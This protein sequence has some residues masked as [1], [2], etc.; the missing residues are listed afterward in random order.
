MSC[1][2]CCGMAFYS[3]KGSHPWPGC[4]FWKSWSSGLEAGCSVALLISTTI[5]KSQT[6]METLLANTL[7]ILIKPAILHQPTCSRNMKVFREKLRA[8]KSYVRKLKFSKLWCCGCE[9][10]NSSKRLDMFLHSGALCLNSCFKGWLQ[11]KT[12]GFMVFKFLTFLQRKN[13]FYQNYSG[14]RFALVNFL[15]QNFQVV[16]V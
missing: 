14:T 1:F 5:V 11:W 2:F 6:E 10:C 9:R 15:I 3:R 4:C 8:A 16:N 13:I 7:D 12:H